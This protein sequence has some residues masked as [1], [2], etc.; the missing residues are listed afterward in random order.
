[1]N[2]NGNDDY[3]S[4][5]SILMDMFPTVSGSILQEHLLKNNNDLELAICLLLKENDEVATTDNELHQLYDMFPHIDCDIIKDQFTANEKSVELTIS[6]LLNY[7]ILQK[8]KEDQTPSHDSVQQDGTKN[9]WKLTND[10]IQTIIKFT[11]APKNIAQKY[12]VENSF[13]SISAVIKIVLD[14]YD[15]DH[16]TQ[17]PTTVNSKIRLT[18]PVKGGRVQSSMGLAH[19]LKQG[20]KSTKESGEN[21]KRVKTYKH[22]SSSPQMI[23]LNE[24][25]EGNHDLKAINH[26]FLQKCLQFYDGDIMKVLDL[27]SLLIKDDK[28]ITKTWNFD[29]GFTLTSQDNCKQHSSKP[30]TPPNSHKNC[31]KKS[32]FQNKETHEEAVAIINNL[33]QTYRLDF[34]GFLPNEAVSILKLALNKW[35]SKEVTE[36]ELNS[37]NINAYGSKVQFVSPLVVVTG[38][39]IHSVGGISKVRLQVKNFLDKNH[40]VFWEESSF[41]RVEGKKRK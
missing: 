5:I 20:E 25:I 33:F 15:K 37:H 31:V 36:R 38:R 11:D 14:Y 24:M 8:L 10:H 39:G 1:M 41:F 9:N 6:D 30:S 18:A 22:S 13:D 21:I 28:S 17:T 7:E 12:F 34:H 40:Y 2:M 19:V 27:S 29:G 16:F 32:P 26:E 23:E 4:Q 3:D 35:W